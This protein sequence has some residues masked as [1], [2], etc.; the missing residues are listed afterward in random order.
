MRHPAMT[1][2]ETGV[3]PSSGPD[4]KAYRMMP[5]DGEQFLAWVPG[6]VEVSSDEDLVVTRSWNLIGIDEESFKF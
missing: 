3:A 5:P 2:T 4:A 1:A 6:L